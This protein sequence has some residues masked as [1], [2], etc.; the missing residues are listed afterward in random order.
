MNKIYKS[1]CFGGD[2]KKGQKR[3]VKQL[4]VAVIVMKKYRAE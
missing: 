3:V 1:P 2:K 4:L